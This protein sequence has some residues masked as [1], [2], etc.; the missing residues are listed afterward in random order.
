MLTYFT[1]KKGRKRLE[2]SKEFPFIIEGSVYMKIM[3]YYIRLRLHAQDQQHMRNSL[4][5]LADV[6]YCSTKNIKI[7]L[8]KM[9]EEQL[10]HWTPGRGRGNKT[11]ILFIHNFVEAIESYTDELLA[12]EN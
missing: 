7:L 8:K 11:E 3:D 1:L 9:S 5:E 4:Q 2:Y 12:Q 6:L 10:I